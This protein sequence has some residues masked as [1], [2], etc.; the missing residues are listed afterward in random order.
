MPFPGQVAYML[1][2]MGEVLRVEDRSIRVLMQEVTEFREL[3]FEDYVPGKEMQG[4]IDEYEEARF[5]R[6]PMAERRNIF[7]RQVLREAYRAN[8]IWNYFRGPILE[9]CITSSH[10]RQRLPHIANK[11]LEAL[12]RLTSRPDAFYTAGVLVYEQLYHLGCERARKVGFQWEQFLRKGGLPA[13]LNATVC[14]NHDILL[15]A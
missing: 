1:A 9:W 8:I 14:C 4:L 3:I 7:A 12:Q 10:A 2:Y 15:S 6:P 5:V 11:G 13:M